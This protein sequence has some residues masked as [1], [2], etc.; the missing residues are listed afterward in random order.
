MRQMCRVPAR[1]R[2][3][4]RGCRTGG[5]RASCLDRY[6]TGQVLAAIAPAALQVSLTAAEAA[7]AE[8]TALDKVWRQRVERAR[9]AAERARRQ[10]QLAEPEN[11][12]VVRQLE[13]DWEAALAERQRLSEEYDRFTA[14]RPRVLTAA[15]REQIRLLAADI[16]AVW[17]APTTTAADRKK[18]IR[19]LIE[20][21]RIAVAGV[22]EKADVDIAW[23]GGHHTQ[24][25]VVR[26][27]ATLAQ[28]SYY[29]QLRERARK[30]IE[31]G[32][33]TAQ[34]AGQRNAER[35]RPPKRTEIFTP[36]AVSDLLRAL[37]ITRNRIPAPRSRPPLAEHE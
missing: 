4:R 7:E 8:R 32:M 16:P 20:Q 26:P 35:F 1:A 2:R 34:I 5:G 17:H 28:L 9:Y 25:Q 15:E 37:G 23:V 12:L 29:P 31:A 14:T 36:N 19:H 22:S 24:G 30:L 13:K 27:V 3:R 18:L 21:V 10:Y 33:T 11:R 6:I